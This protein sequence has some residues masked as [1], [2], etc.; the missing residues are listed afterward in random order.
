M[1]VDISKK[2]TFVV[3]AY[4]ESQYLEEC[5]Q[6]VLNQNIKSNVIIST[7]TPN[8]YIKEIAEKYK[9]QL[10]VNPKP[11]SLASDWNFAMSCAKTGLVTL[12][13]QDDVYEKEYSEN[14]WNAYNKSKNPIIL[15]SDYAELRD[16]KTVLKNKLLTI[17]RIMLSPLKIPVLWNSKFIRRRIL[18]FGSAICCPAVTMVKSMVPSNLFEDNMKI[19]IDW[20]AWELLSR[21][22]GSFVYVS[23]PLMEHRIH[24]ESTTSDLLKDSA[25]KAE[26]L[27]VFQK[28]WP[29]YIALLIEKVYQKGEKSNQLK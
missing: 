29:K 10:F 17:K 27:L 11:S 21:K 24:E 8:S 22:K 2:H 23:K 25:R 4:K 19:N 5:I 26:D 15:F 18:S 1:K 7:G 12:A 6:S 16:G 28:F 20:Q 3:C 13:H 14:I 9:L